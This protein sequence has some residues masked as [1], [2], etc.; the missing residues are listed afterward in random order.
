MGGVCQFEVEGFHHILANDSTAV[1]IDSREA[2]E[3][4]KGTIRGARNIP[5]SLVLDG[6][7]IGEVRRAKDDGR[8][9]MEDHNTRI[10]VVG[11]DAA[12]ARYVAEALTREAF[13]N[14]SYFG[15]SIAALREPAAKAAQFPLPSNL[16]V[17]PIYREFVESMASR[18]PTFR[19]Q[20]L[21]I[22]AEP[23][24]TVDLEMVPATR[25]ARARA[26]TSIVRH[27]TGIAARVEMMR[28]DDIVELIAHEIEHVI[29]Q[30]DGV[31]LAACAS[32]PGTG[33]HAIPADGIAY[34]TLRATRVGVRVS[35]E[36]RAPGEPAD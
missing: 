34:E 27:T 25:S 9:P 33:V 15:G 17:T 28:L 23:R 3:F 31:D 21:R 20:L 11:S 18:S 5:R 36:L 29:E 10:L 32:L 30:I 35:R 22:A 7:D 16:N 19:R 1:I 12:A 8:L 13:H 4:S 6:K 14:V 24:L 2:A 26:K